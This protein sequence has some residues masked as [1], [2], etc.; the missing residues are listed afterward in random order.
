MKLYVASHSQPAARALKQQL[1]DEGH[2]VVAR[3][4]ASDI[5][6]GHGPDAYTDGERAALAVMDETDVRVC[7]ALILIAEPEGR[8]VPGGKHVETGIALALQKPVFVLG[9]R[10]NI[11]HWHPRVQVVTTSDDLMGLL[12][13]IAFL[14]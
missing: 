14:K 9:R 7:E 10:E 11:F 12:G 3:W 8:T 13:L 1:E 4:I 5:K 2:I 6:F